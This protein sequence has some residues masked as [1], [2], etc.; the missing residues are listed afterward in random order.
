MN[1]YHD[2]ARLPCS[3]DSQQCQYHPW[4][5]L[6]KYSPLHRRTPY[7]GGTSPATTA[8]K[9]FTVLLAELPVL[10]FLQVDC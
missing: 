7:R 5:N 9:S 8:R 4:S 10:N 2:N 1:S 6:Q 3:S